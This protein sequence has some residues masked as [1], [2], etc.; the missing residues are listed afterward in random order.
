[1][2]SIAARLEMLG[3]T[4]CL[5]GL[6]SAA[7]QPAPFPLQSQKSSLNAIGCFEFKASAKLDWA[8]NEVYDALTHPEK[9]ATYISAVR[10]LRAIKSND[11]NSEI[12]EWGG[13]PGRMEPPPGHEVWFRVHYAFDR[14]QMKLSIER[15]GDQPTTNSSTTYRVFPIAGA[16]GG[17]LLNVTDLQCPRPNAPNEFA[18]KDSQAKSAAEVSYSER[19]FIAGVDA[20]LFNLHRKP[21]S[22]PDQP[23]PGETA[24]PSVRTP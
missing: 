5:F 23:Q 24:T 6:A 16:R 7:A 18:S 1:M 4:P 13:P 14:P 21:L 15:L 12:L 19:H 22:N 11:G 9:M 3:L 8:P 2:L 10:L 20:Y 17:S